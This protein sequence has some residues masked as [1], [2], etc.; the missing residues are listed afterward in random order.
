M[1][2]CLANK[3]T[4]VLLGMFSYR[5]GVH[6]EE[7]GLPSNIHQIVSVLLEPICQK[8]GLGLIETAT[9]GVKGSSRSCLL[10]GAAL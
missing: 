6:H 1:A 3:M 9:D 8:R 4:A 5:A 7:I 10:H 2:K